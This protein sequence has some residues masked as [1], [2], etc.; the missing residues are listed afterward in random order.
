[1]D[2]LSPTWIVLFFS[3][4]YVLIT[5]SQHSGDP[6]AFVRVGARFDPSLGSLTMGYD[7]QF[8]FQIAADPLTAAEHLDVP[9]YRYQRILY[10]L[11]AR[12]LSLG[13]VK[14]LPWALITINL[15]AITLGTWLTEHIL[16]ANHV[17]R[18]YALAFGLNI[19]VLMALRLDLNEPLAFML[20]QLGLLAWFRKRY[21]WSAVAFALAALTKEV[22]LIL[23][24]GLAL[25]LFLT[26]ERKR[27]IRW[28]LIAIVPYSIW[29][30]VL[31]IALGA[32]APQAGGA[33]ATGFQWL[34]YRGWWGLASIQPENF[35]L[36]SALIVPLAIVPSVF[37]ILLATDQVRRR[38]HFAVSCLLG[39]QSL[40]YCFLPSS[41]LLDPLG[42]SRFGIG[43]I[44][45]LLVF[46]AVTGRQRVLAFTQMSIMTTLFL[47]QDSFLPRG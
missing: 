25:G 17:R 19:G 5:L 34:P 22:T 44:V 15:A 30:V 37:G 13:S 8:A 7:G 20:V 47:W 26:G 24:A 16:R 2:L 23:A 1:M 33:L 40:T 4:I 41:V 21:D 42:I 14:L 45:A 27:S 10:P 38:E 32:W 29:V 43:T 18:W 9:A 12:L 39:L 3:L 6:M 31:R 36:V 35:A 46:G 11:L 28:G